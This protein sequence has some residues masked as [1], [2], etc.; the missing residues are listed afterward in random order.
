[1]KIKSNT[2]LK[3]LQ[4]KINCKLD[5][6]MSPSCPHLLWE[7]MRYSVLGDGKRLRGILCIESCKTFKGSEDISLPTACAIE[8]IHAQS[9]IHDDLPCMD[10]DDFRR[11]KPSTHKQFG[12][13]QAILA[14]DALIPF[15]YEVFLKHTPPSVSDKT[16]L[17]IIEEFSKTIGAHG[18][19]GGQVVDVENAGI[20][21]DSETLNYIHS[22]KT[23]A[24]YNFALRSGAILANCSDK[25]L[26]LI[27]T[28]SK[29][30]GLA[31]QI[32]DDILDIT[33][34]K[35]SLGKTPGKDKASGKN[36]Y[37]SVYG[38]E[39][40]ISELNNLC[41]LAKDTLAHNNIKS[42]VLIDIAD[43]IAERI[44]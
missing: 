33:G 23:G 19:V 7:S 38:L 1:M 30:I 21:V 29:A 36:T 41:K 15:A 32:S 24:L 8:I 27:T 11:G 18:L 42:E 9:L 40:S 4:S 26:E 2:Y 37:P 6:Y 31:F 35:E 16:K 39:N 43:F 13:A 10:N 5:E 17:T 20:Q 44:K 12:A 34:S 3:E 14:G 22:N 25:E 28:Y